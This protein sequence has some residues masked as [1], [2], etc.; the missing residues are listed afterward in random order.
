MVMLDD[1][2]IHD[3]THI[4]MDRYTIAGG[5][6]LAYSDFK[7]DSV[8]PPP[9]NEA[10]SFEPIIPLKQVPIAQF[11]ADKLFQYSLLAQSQGFTPPLL[12]L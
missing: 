2:G 5:I 12:V 11:E 3:Q 1:V 10:T 6:T 9:A 7:P 8:Y 4:W